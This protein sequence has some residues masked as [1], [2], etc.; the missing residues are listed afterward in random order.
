MSQNFGFTGAN[1]GQVQPWRLQRVCG[2]NNRVPGTCELMCYCHTQKAGAKHS[3]PPPSMPFL[4]VTQYIKRGFVLNHTPSIAPGAS[5]SVQ[6]EEVNR[7]C[8]ARTTVNSRHSLIRRFQTELQCIRKREGS[9]STGYQGTVAVR[10]AL[11]GV[12]VSA[13]LALYSLSIGIRDCPVVYNRKFWT[14]I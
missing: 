12:W 9:E 13:A 8:P 1:L 5:G 6:L 2:E 7:K 3:V 10:T 11:C 4:E 14:Q